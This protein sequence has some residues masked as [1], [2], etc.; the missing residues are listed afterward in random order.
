MSPA[1]NNHKEGLRTK[2]TDSPKVYLLWHV[3]HQAEG[4]GEIRHF[5]DPDDFWADEEAGD[6]VKLLGTYSSREAAQ[7]RIERARKLPGFREEPNC[8][9]V[10]EYVVDEDE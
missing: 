2:T 1:W 9:H 4:E 3:H 8:F 5:V 6:G 7:N 10:D